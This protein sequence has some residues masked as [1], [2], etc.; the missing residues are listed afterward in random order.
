LHSPGN[1][2]RRLHSKCPAFAT[3]SGNL[4]K[5][6]LALRALHYTEL[7]AHMKRIEKKKRADEKLKR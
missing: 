4:K 6:I 7:E 1:Q 5:R 2:F 3:L